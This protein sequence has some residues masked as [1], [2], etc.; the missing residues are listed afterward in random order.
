MK[1]DPQPPRSEGLAGSVRQLAGSM[2]RVLSTRL[3]ILSTEIAEERIHFTRL[4]LVSLVAL[5]C[6]VAGTLLGVLFLILTV[7]AEHQL[8]AIGISAL[9]LLV[10]AIGS[11][12][13]LFWWLKH[14]PPMFASTIA[15]L[16]KDRDRLV[17]KK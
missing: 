4:L 16:Q 14:R 5:F 17:G 15:E 10:V 13:W 7:G 9:S 12:L 3:E 1:T 11:A 6:L 2:L 8:A